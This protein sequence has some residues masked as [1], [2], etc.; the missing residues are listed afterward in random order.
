MDVRALLA[1][2]AQVVRIADC[3][4]AAFPAQ[5]QGDLTETFH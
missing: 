5:A 2:V 3:V 1:V 4:F